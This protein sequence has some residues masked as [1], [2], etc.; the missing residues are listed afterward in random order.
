M[1]A[2]P[3]PRSRIYLILAHGFYLRPG[4]PAGADH[5]MGA[6]SMM[7]GGEHAY[8]SARFCGGKLHPLYPSVPLKELFCSNRPVSVSGFGRGTLHWPPRQS[9]KPS[10][11]KV[12]GVRNTLWVC[13]FLN[14]SQIDLMQNRWVVLKGPKWYMTSA[15]LLWP[16]FMRRAQ[17]FKGFWL[18]QLVG[19]PLWCASSLLIWRFAVNI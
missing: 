17:V 18:P 9:G 19:D 12:S 1:P 6:S 4:R 10:R 16:L 8:Q 3:S 7:L 11:Q 5:C 2:K 15:R 13:A 14:F